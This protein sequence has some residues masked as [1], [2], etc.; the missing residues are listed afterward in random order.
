M[1]HNVER[2]N[3]GRAY[4]RWLVC[5]AVVLSMTAL[6]FKPEDLKSLTNPETV[7]KQISAKDKRTCSQSSSSEVAIQSDQDSWELPPLAFMSLIIGKTGAVPRGSG[8][9]SHNRAPPLF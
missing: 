7:F 8:Y 2:L 1:T 6:R 4:W 5:I 9:A 3:R